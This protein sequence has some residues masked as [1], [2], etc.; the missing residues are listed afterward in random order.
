MMCVRI[1]WGWCLGWATLTQPSPASGRGLLAGRDG[2]AVCFGWGWGCCCGVGGRVEPGYTGRG[3]LGVVGDGALGWG[4]PHPTLSRQRARAFGWG[5]MG[6]L[7]VL[8]G[9]GLLLRRGWPGRARPHGGCWGWCFGLGP[10]SPNPLPPAGEGFWLA[11]MGRLFVLGGGGIFVA[12]WVAG[13]S[14]ATRRL[15]GMVLWVGPSSPEPVLP[16]GWGFWL[17]AGVACGAGGFVMRDGL[18]GLWARDWA[19]L[20]EGG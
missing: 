10:P 3:G 6:R 7:F 11:G 16:A 19:G 17:P 20:V 13:S 4:H 5:G 9:V 2:A 14:P 15:L 12:A 18:L 8:G 1:G